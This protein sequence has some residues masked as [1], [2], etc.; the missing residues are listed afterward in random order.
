MPLLRT[1]CSTLLALALALAALSGCTGAGRV[2][3]GK[4]DYKVQFG[5][6]KKGDTEHQIRAFHVA[7]LGG[8]AGD[9]DALA[10]VLARI[11]ESG[12]NAVAFD[13]AGLSPEALDPASVA[14]VV[15]IAQRTKDQ[16]MA[17]LVRIAP[18]GDA[19][20]RLQAVQTAAAAL[21]GERRA[22]YWIDAPEA[23][24]LAAAFKKA[25]PG[26]LVAATEG[27]DLRMLGAE[28][29]TAPGALDILLWALPAAGPESAH[30]V[31][32]DAPE[33]YAAL[34]A[35][36]LNPAAREEWTPDNSALSPAER[37]EGF[38]A[39]FN[40]R[41]LSGWWYWGDNHN[42]FKVNEAGEIEY[43]ESGGSAIMTRDRYADFVLRLEFLIEQ[44]GNSGIFLRSPRAARQSYIG[45]EFQ[46]HGDPDAPVGDDM[47]GALYK[48]LPPLVNASRPAGEWNEL[49]ITCQGPHLKA[50]LNGTV[51]QDT[52]L[53]E[54]PELKH[55]LRSGFIGLQDH[56]NYVKFRNVRIKP[57]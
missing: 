48:Q 9:T 4:D 29:E 10:P 46:I 56:D 51:I 38:I 34:D 6:F 15:A 11:A 52:N 17:A 53:D 18:E 31:L 26:L 36:M 5:Q 23:A 12:G 28:G 32:A 3:W 35:A 2:I 54:H 7:G 14:T 33:H 57:L 55:R 49:E 44:G 39:L 16:R 22:L 50:I 42:T 45:M 37:D 27:G 13:L 30:F 40:G 1:P 25:A 19:A 20:A 24:T 21:Q 47:V 43:V 8:T 41:D